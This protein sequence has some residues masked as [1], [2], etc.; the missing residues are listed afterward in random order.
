MTTKV[1]V[2][3]YVW[4]STDPEREVLEA[5]G[6]ELVIAPDTS[7]ATLAELAKDVDAI[8]FC[9]AQVT[10]KVLE[11]ATHC[12]I[13]ARYGIGVDNV[14]ITKATELGIVVTNVPD[15]CMDEV[16]DHALG[17]ILALNRRLVPHTNAVVGGGWNDV[18]LN[19]PMHRT[20]GATLGIVGY[21]RIG[22][23][24]AAKAAGFGMNILAYDPLIEI[25][26]EIDGA[27]VV[28]LDD[29]LAKSD[30]VSLHVPLMPSTQ[31]MISAPE[32]AKMKQGS[33]IVNCARGGL[34]DETALAE[35]LA[36]GQT[37]GAG[38]DVVEPTP[39]DPVSA[40]LQQ[41]NVIITPHTAFFSQASTLELEQRTAQ[42]VVRVLKG[43]KPE[44]LINPAVLGK[45]RSGI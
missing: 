33:I 13:A 3:D 4:P 19:Q 12:K 34:I 36:S 23:S 45:A 40:L 26:S 28:S 11:S 27:S 32:L 14:D 9:F 43:E 29:L 17:M 5:A 39:P 7:E 24:L 31:N 20:R 21:G 35:S 16:T 6:I 42:E 10:S 2:T 1:L 25:G 8:M 38:L 44:N 18:I 22:R 37:A 41:E 30:F 15:Y